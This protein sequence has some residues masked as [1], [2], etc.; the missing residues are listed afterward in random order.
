MHYPIFRFKHQDREVC[1]GVHLFGHIHSVPL[2][3]PKHSFNVGADIN[4]YTPVE[5]ETAISYAKSNE[6]GKVNAT[7]SQEWARN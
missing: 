5:L 6:G 2:I 7:R 4:N 3:I 1:M